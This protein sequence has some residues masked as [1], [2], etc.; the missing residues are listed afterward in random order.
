MPAFDPVSFAPVSA[1]GEV[2]PVEATVTETLALTSPAMGI[3]QMLLQDSAG[4]A[5]STATEIWTPVRE[6]LVLGE[7]NLGVAY[8]A[9]TVAEF[10]QLRSVMTPVTQE[11]VLELLAL[12]GGV[13]A[14]NATVMVIV[15]ALVLSGSA[16]NTLTAIGAV[17]EALAFAD[18]LAS[19]HDGV[20]ADTASFT[21]LLEAKLSAYAALVSAAVFSD[22]AAGMANVTV[23]VAD[24]LSFDETL[25]PTVALIAAIQEGLAF[26]VGFSFAGEPY[27]GLSLNATTRGLTTYTNY[28]FNSMAAFGGQVYGAS[29]SGLFRL[30]GATDAGTQIVWRM[31]TGMT[32]FDTGRAKGIDAAYLGY[33]ATGDVLL[34]CIVVSSSGAKMGYWYKLT[35]QSATNPRP[36]RIPIGRGLRSVYW[37][38]ELT[39]ETSGDI[40]LD[41]LE[42]HPVI[43]EGRLP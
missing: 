18:A 30:G 7:M 25:S 9:A 12:D 4:F 38:F 20:V 36:G 33:T 17:A 16:T 37:G 28:P 1:S 3:Y 34:K 11:L 24:A 26:S 43:L 42:L 15:D 35:P 14:N 27:L 5:D 2:V 21:T 22:V 29:E 13:E 19:V 41:V 32:N 31:R 23:L 8:M 10:M 39:N 6:A 40:E